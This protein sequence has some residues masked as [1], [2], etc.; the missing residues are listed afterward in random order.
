MGSSVS[1]EV[2]SGMDSGGS[3]EALNEN[4]DFPLVL[5]AFSEDWNSEVDPRLDSEMDSGIQY[6]KNVGFSL[7]LQAFPC[8]TE[9]RNTR[10][11]PA[12]HSRYTRDTPEKHPRRA[13]L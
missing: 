12:I 1:S 8:A 6:L 5:H 7:V 13:P 11:T 3:E 10:K 9:R 4:V 2:D